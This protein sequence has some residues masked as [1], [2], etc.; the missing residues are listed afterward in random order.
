[1][2]EFEHTMPIEQL[3]E[4]LGVPKVTAGISDFILMQRLASDG[5]NILPKEK[6]KAS[7]L[8]M[9]QENLYIFPLLLY[10]NLDSNGFT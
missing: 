2:E 3:I 6:L 7:A 1:M 9:F 5:Y 10:S 4:K 8:V